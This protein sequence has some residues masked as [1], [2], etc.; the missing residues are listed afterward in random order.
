[1]AMASGNDDGEYD[2]RESARSAACS[3]EARRRLARRSC[4][5]ICRRRWGIR[6]A[7]LFDE[8]YISLLINVSIHSR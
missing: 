8:H 7:D 5:W 6:L 2:G 1:M 4:S 3:R